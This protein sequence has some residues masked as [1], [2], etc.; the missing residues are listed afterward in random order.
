[1]RIK[2]IQTKYGTITEKHGWYYVSSNEHGHRG[3]ALHRVIFEDYHKCT[4][5]PWAN[6]HHRNF[7]KHDNRIENL[8]LLS[9]SE[10]QKIHKA[11]YKPSEMHKKAISKGL[12][13]RKLDVIHRINLR[14]SKKRK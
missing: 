5:L 14:R 4:L 11:L 13:G 8:Q 1:M 12:K 2:S 10:H 7:N 3:K 6:I 9:A